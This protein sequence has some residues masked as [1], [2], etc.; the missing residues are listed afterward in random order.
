MIAVAYEHGRA[1]NVAGHLE[2]DDVID[3]SDTRRIVT[4]TFD[5]APARLHGVSGRSFIDRR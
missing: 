3:P 5:R 1:L 4:T 2:V